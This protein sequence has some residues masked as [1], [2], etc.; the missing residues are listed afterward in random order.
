VN[1]CFYLFLPSCAHPV[2]G[3]WDVTY[4]S[5]CIKIELN[6]YGAN[7]SYCPRSVDEGPQ[8]LYY[9]S[10][11]VTLLGLE[12]CR[13]THTMKRET[14]LLTHRAAVRKDFDEQFGVEQDLNFIRKKSNWHRQNKAV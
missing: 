2:I 11:R 3:F 14:M 10:P 9:R 12:K 6:H 5:N 1:V 13:L 4:T 7:G 8:K